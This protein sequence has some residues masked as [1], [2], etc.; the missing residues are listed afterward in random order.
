MEWNCCILQHKFFPELYVYKWML[1]S[2]SGVF[3]DLVII[4]SGSVVFMLIFLFVCFL[5][6][7]LLKLVPVTVEGHGG[8]LRRQKREWILA[9][10]NLTEGTDYTTYDYVAKVC[11]YLFSLFK[12]LFKMLSRKPHFEINTEHTNIYL[13]NLGSSDVFGWRQ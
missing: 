5:L 8:V 4:T 7:V 10:R 3:Y 2:S 1:N 6:F 12:I 13:K 9:P 11:T